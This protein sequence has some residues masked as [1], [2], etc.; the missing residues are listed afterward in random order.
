MTTK[1]KLLLT[2]SLISF[3]FGFTEVLWGVGKPIGAILFGLFLIFKLLEKEVALFDNE[4][5]QQH[6]LAAKR[7]AAPQ[8]VAP[9]DVQ[10]GMAAAATRPG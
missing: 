4:L 8:S 2:L 3:A 7:A 9:T 1:T 10:S 5:E 6:A